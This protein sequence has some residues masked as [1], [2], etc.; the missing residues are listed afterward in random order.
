MEKKLNSLVNVPDILP[1]TQLLSPNDAPSGIM[2][3]TGFGGSGT[4]LFGGIGGT[5]PELYREK[6]ADFIAFAGISAGNPVKAV[7][8]AAGVNM[9]NVNQFKNFSVNFTVSRQLSV[10]SSISVG[11][12]GLLAS[13]I[14]SDAAASTF[15]F[16]FS[17]AVQWAPSKTPGASALSYTIGIGTG[18]FMHKSPFDVQNGK[19]KKA[20]AVFAGVS[21][22]ILKHVN[23]AAEWYGTNL[24]VS[25]GFRPF[26]NPLSIGLGVDNLTSYSGDR[27]SMIVTIG[28]PLN[29]RRQASN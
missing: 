21:Y 29:I 13:N 24:G 25:A 14:Q 15:Y 19:G 28:Y 7:N 18:R 3:P 8:V 20:T 6:Q 22:E 27:A 5:Y 11:G 12:L 4:Y 2:S 17:H 16:A 23:M 10:A 1:K 26:A 9:A